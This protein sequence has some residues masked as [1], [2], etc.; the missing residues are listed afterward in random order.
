MEVQPREIQRYVK[1][2]GQIPFD[3]WFYALRDSQAKLRINVRLKR[4]STGNFGDLPLS[5]RRSLGIEN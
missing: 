2:D 3:E 1:S 5:G 4:V